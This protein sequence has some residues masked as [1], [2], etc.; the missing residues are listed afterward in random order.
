LVSTQK[1][2]FECIKLR[3]RFRSLYHQKS[4]VRDFVGTHIPSDSPLT[5][6]RTADAKLSKMGDTGRFKS[7]GVAS[8]TPNS[9]S[10][11]LDERIGD[12]ASIQNR[13]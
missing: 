5:A 6:K 3:V 11:A 13:S 7:V 4:L 12:S 9:Y 2:L 8:H 1:L 10:L